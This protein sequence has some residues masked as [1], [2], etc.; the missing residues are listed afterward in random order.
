V[1]HIRAVT[2]QVRQGDGVLEAH[3]TFEVQRDEDAPEAWTTGGPWLTLGGG[4]LDPGFDGLNL[5]F[6]SEISCIEEDVQRRGDRSVRAFDAIDWV[7]CD[8]FSR[9]ALHALGMLKP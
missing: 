5:A 9:D 7:P 6:D 3:F 2:G 4:H 1:H 8:A